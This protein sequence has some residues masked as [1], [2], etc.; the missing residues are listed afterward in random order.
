MTANDPDVSVFQ[1]SVVRDPEADYVP[2]SRMLDPS[3]YKDTT[4]PGYDEN[5]FQSK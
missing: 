5:D 4:V 3:S 2:Q 1:S